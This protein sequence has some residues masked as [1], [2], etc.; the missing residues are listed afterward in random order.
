ML[1]DVTQFLALGGWL[2]ALA[3]SVL[4]AGFVVD[5]VKS[6]VAN[7]ARIPGV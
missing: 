1:D 5:Q 3:L 2:V 4:L 6:Q 7:L